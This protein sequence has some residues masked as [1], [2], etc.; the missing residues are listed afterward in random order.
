MVLCNIILFKLERYGFDRYSMDK[1][2]VARSY[3]ES[4]GQWLS[5]WMEIGDE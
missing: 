4:D 1:E 2:L 3:P 5:V